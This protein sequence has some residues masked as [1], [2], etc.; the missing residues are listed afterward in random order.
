[1]FADHVNSIARHQAIGIARQS[2]ARI[3]RDGGTPR[4]ALQAFAI[5][6]RDFDALALTWDKAVELIAEALCTT[7]MRRAA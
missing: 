4:D 6:R 7:P 5:L 2:C 3:F 1:M